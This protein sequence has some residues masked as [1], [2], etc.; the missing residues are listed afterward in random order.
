MKTIILNIDMPRI[1]I[2]LTYK[3]KVTEVVWPLNDF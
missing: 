3:L 1:A 2:Y